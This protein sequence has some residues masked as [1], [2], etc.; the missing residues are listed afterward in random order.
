MIKIAKLKLKKKI[1]KFLNKLYLSLAVILILLFLGLLSNYY[2]TINK[3]LKP[4]SSE[5]DYYNISDFGFIR[6]I[7][8][9][10]YDNDGID[11]YTDILNGEKIVAKINPKYVNE[12][13]AG[14]YPPETEGVCT[15]VIWRSLKEA[16][17]SL[18]DMISQDI[19]DEYDKKTYNIS[20]IDDNIDFRRVLNQEIFF[21]RYA[22]VLDTDIYKVG[23]LMPGDILVFNDSEHIAMVSDKYNKN[24][25]PYLIQNRD[26]SQKETEEDRLEET[27]MIVTG[28]YRFKYNDKIQ[29]LIN[30]INE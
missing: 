16:G 19:R 1:K 21:Q 29:E 27:D 26:S 18:K 28:H 30:R 5:K 24:G 14:G 20:I 3:N 23:D 17:Y 2:L 10:D 4:I 6:E 7:S 9:K 13:Y 11:D 22:E 12:Y 25:I 15:D 8:P